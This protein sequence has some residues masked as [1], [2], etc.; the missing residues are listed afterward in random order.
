MSE[1]QLDFLNIF[2][3]SEPRDKE[4]KFDDVL[5]TADDSDEEDDKQDPLDFNQEEIYKREEAERIFKQ[6]QADQERADKVEARKRV[7]DTRNTPPVIAFE[8]FLPEIRNYALRLAAV[9]EAHSRV[10]G[11]A[12]L[13]LYNRIVW[14]D[15]YEEEMY[16][17]S[18]RL[19]LNYLD[20]LRRS[21]SSRRVSTEAAYLPPQDKKKTERK[22]G[23]KKL[24]K[25]T[26]S[27]AS[28][29]KGLGNNVD[30]LP[31]DPYS[32]IYPTSRRWRS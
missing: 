2:D 23:E 10:S 20:A 8:E 28:D 24:S 9:K 5:S 27:P 31:D 3:K 19:Y 30:E 21:K 11:E 32:D 18:A 22:P 26:E 4:K 29:E 6:Q 1:K 7:L 15:I 16:K 12:K 25:T 17:E 13:A 14:P